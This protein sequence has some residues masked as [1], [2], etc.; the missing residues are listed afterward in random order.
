METI[1][2]RILNKLKEKQIKQNA[3]ANNIGVS[4]SALTHYIK[5]NNIPSADI[6][7]KIALELDTTTDYLIHGKIDI[8]SIEEKMLLDIYNKLNDKNKKKIALEI[9]H[10]YDLQQI[11]N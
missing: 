10:L 7:G 2:D 4:K 5:N 11:E 8:E 3:L 6:I 1:G 9:R